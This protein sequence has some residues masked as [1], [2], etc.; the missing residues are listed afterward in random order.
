MLRHKLQQQSNAATATASGHAL[1]SKRG[2]GQPACL[3]VASAQ[4]ISPI[5]SNLVVVV[6]QCMSGFEIG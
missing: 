2:R 1:T 4:R 6:L 5:G 3:L